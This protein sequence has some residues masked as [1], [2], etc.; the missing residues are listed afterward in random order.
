MLKALLV[1][2]FTIVFSSSS[3]L[4]DRYAM[5]Y[6][7]FIHLNVNEKNEFIIKTMEIMVELE[8]KYEKAVITDGPDS[9]KARN[10]SQILND[11]K[12]FLIPVAYAQEA[13]IPQYASDFANLIGKDD[14]SAQGSKCFYAGWISRT[15]EISYKNHKGETIKKEVCLHPGRLPKATSEYKA[16][17]KTS[18]CTKPDPMRSSANDKIACNPVIFGLK[19]KS[20]NKEFC[21]DSGSHHAV[22]SSLNCMKLALSDENTNQDSREERLKFLR[23]Q[24]ES[25]PALARNFF[26]FLSKACLCEDANLGTLSSMY[27]SS[28]RPHRTCFALLNMMAETVNCAETEIEGLETGFIKKIKEHSISIQ[29]PNSIDNFY[30][31]FIGKLKT[32]NPAEYGRICSGVAAPVV[33][34]GP[35]VSL[36]CTATCTAVE[37]EAP[38]GEAK[39]LNCKYEAKNKKT[40]EVI[41]L[42]TSEG[43]ASEGQEVELKVKDSEETVKCSATLK[44]GKEEKPTCVITLSE[45]GEEKNASVSAGDHEIQ[46]VA[47]NHAPDVDNIFITLTEEDK[48]KE[49]G[50]TATIKAGTTVIEGIVCTLATPPEEIK[51]GEKPTITVKVT[52]QTPAANTYEAT[53]GG[54]DATGWTIVWSKEGKEA[55]AIEGSQKKVTVPNGKE[56]FKVCA[57]LEKG[58]EKT[59]KSCAS[60]RAAPAHNGPIM[61]NRNPGGPMRGNSGTSAYGIR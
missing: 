54:G 10:Y 4:A 45:N 18:S 14:P 48:D 13:A 19:D 5:N 47:W 50:A 41:S 43:E 44:D 3:V 11:L 35:A 60:P 38:E 16:Y 32:D 37:G 42:E 20:Q 58:E 57:H 56:A 21:V 40:D 7:K 30:D 1:F 34:T 55:G 25:E 39:K 59:A 27:A 2:I 36:T 24:L 46:K 61:Q 52:N 17:N 9:E 8:S 33:A 31:S 6:E 26:N 28:V 23:S 15:T 29:T 53:V 12:S 49:I 51:D 22:N